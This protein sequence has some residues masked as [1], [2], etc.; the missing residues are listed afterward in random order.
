MFNR[1]QRAASRCA[2]RLV[3]KLQIVLGWETVTRTILLNTSRENRRNRIATS[4]RK[5]EAG[6]NDL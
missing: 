6:V 5:V 3:C 4:E 1:A 2:L